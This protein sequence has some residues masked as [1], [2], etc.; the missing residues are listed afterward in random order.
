MT[1]AK[2]TGNIVS[3][4]KHPHYTGHKLLIVQPIDPGGNPKGKPLLAVDGVQAGVG[5]RV[6]VVDEGGS[7]RQTIGDTDAV[8]IR[9]A[10]CAIVDRVDLEA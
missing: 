8:T 6:L 9:T 10:I 3:T 5:D 2:V 1:L 4:E 7:A